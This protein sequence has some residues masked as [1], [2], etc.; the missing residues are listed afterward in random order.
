MKVAD[1]FKWPPFLN[2]GFRKKKKVF[3]WRNLKS[4]GLMGRD[5]KRK[6]DEKKEK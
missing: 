6:L 3:E 4:H 2:D 1:A 5:E